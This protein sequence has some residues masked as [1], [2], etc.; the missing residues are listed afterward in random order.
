MKKNLF[1][2]IMSLLILPLTLRAQVEKVVV[3]TYYIADANDAKDTLGGKLEEGSKTYRVYIVLKSGYK[4]KKIYGDANH[5]LR[6]SSTS[7]FFNN[8]D[9]GQTFGM[10]FSK[11]HFGKNTV[12]LDTWLTIGQTSK[13]STSAAA[14]TY[15]GV[16]KSDDTDGSFVGGVNN[17]GGS[18]ELPEGLLANADAAAGIPLTTADGLTV[19]TQAPTNWASYG[20]KDVLSGDDSTIFG[21]V[22]PGKE[23]L[24]RNAALQNSGVAGV[25]PGNNKILVAQLT[26]KGE[27]SFELNIELE[28][29]LKKTLVYVANDSTLL[30]GEMLERYLTF[31]FNEI[32][33]CPD[34]NYIE[35]LKDRDCD[36]L[37]A[38]RSQIVFGCMDPMS[39]N[40]DPKA[41]Y[42]LPELCCYPGFC[43]DRDISLVCPKLGDKVYSDL[44]FNIYPNPAQSKMTIE[45]ASPENKDVSYA[46]YDSFGTAV[47]LKSGTTMSD[48]SVQ[49]V[50]LS[51]LPEGLYL[52]RLYR[53]G[54]VAS[55]RFIKK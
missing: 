43:N 37:N 4:L 52:I 23:F 10:D 2:F 29:S 41:N 48:A 46:I 3:E 18:M 55:K 26:T 39:C 25:S 31:P 30:P 22:I 1:L 27:L 34:R 15:C 51:S 40:F 24:S 20:F 14:K 8:T 38:C 45:I 42:N 16:L 50:D 36:N 54:T 6:F 11:S 28:D 35:Y 44:E 9:R 32:C 21:S 19:M 5:P 13:A 33:G 17:D 49:D 53:D 7:D 12:G 47:L